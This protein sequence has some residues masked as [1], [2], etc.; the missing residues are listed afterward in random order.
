MRN[1]GYKIQDIGDIIDDVSKWGVKV[2]CLSDDEFFGL[3]DQTEKSQPTYGKML[4]KKLKVPTCYIDDDERILNSFMRVFQKLIQ[5]KD[6]KE[7]YDALRA[8]EKIW[9]KIQDDT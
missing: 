8:Y 9:E 1:I 3:F 6:D 2:R 4:I 7:F 5:S